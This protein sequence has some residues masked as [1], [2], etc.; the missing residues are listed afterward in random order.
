MQE[1]KN[2]EANGP[3]D[4]KF[5][6]FL[7]F[8]KLSKLKG[9]ENITSQ[10]DE[11]VNELLSTLDTSSSSS[12]SSSSSE[13]KQGNAGIISTLDVVSLL[14]PWAIKNILRSQNDPNE[15][16]TQWRTLEHCLKYL[17]LK[18]ES[19]LD[20]LTSNNVLPLGTLNKLVPMAGKVA[21]HRG[22]GLDTLSETAGNC[23]CLLVDH[24][25]SAPFDVVCDSLLTMV[26]LIK[27]GDQTLQSMVLSTLRLL[28]ARIKKANAKK[29]FQLLVK[30][31][32]FHTL[33]EI[34]A[35]SEKW[36]ESP[37]PLVK[38]LLVH[39]LFDLDHHIDGFRSIKMVI[40]SI[41]IE[42]TTEVDTEV[43]N[44]VEA[45]KKSDFHCYQED[46]LALIQGELSTTTKDGT[47]SKKAEES[48]VIQLLP[49]LLES[50]I[51]QS[52]SLRQ[53]IRDKASTNKKKASGNKIMN[54]QFQFFAFIA[55]FLMKLFNSSHTHEEASRDQIRIKVLVTLEKSLMLLLKYDI[56]LPSNEDN[57]NDHFS[58]LCNLGRALIHKM[59]TREQSKLVLSVDERE[60]ALAILDTLVRLNHLILHDQISEIVAFCLSYKVDNRSCKSSEFLGTLIVTY[61]K[62]RQ[63]DYF[64][65]SFVEGVD[66]MRENNSVEG[67]KAM[68]DLMQDPNICS[69][70]SEA[71]RSS[72]INQGVFLATQSALNFVFP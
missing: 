3:P 14:L 68:I 48:S 45:P 1:E 15:S 70:L 22:V 11:V 10:M 21:F 32:I 27:S 44:N 25:Y 72:P 61:K 69:S 66:L 51:E 67:L 20:Y 58:F 33:S 43:E 36:S 64:C 29:S 16:K 50:F 8:M 42:Q 60:N 24:F 55:G 28:C 17:I 31:D 46:L 54:L 41:Q 39:G 30:P 5:D 13:T 12:S 2:E 38:E 71:I 59:K 18:S 40:P 4:R 47:A 6:S 62:L 26:G 19:T 9:D 57:N 49:L 52:L 34:Y 37:H 56:Y 53:Q 63:L 7:S 65:S 35:Q 23:Y